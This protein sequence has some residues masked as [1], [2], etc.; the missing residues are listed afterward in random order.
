MSDKRYFALELYGGRKAVIGRMASL[1]KE[2][3]EKYPGDLQEISGESGVPVETLDQIQK[4]NGNEVVD[5]RLFDQ[6]ASS[7]FELT[8]HDALGEPDLSDPKIREYWEGQMKRKPMLISGGS[9]S[10]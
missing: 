6:L 2:A 7:V 8:I 1:I 3:M 10:R 9:S 4:G 5:L